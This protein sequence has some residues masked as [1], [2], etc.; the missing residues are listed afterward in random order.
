[1]PPLRP[2]Y[3]G[4][5]LILYIIGG[6]FVI[7]GEIRAQEDIITTISNI[8]AR[9]GA[10]GMTSGITA[11]ALVETW[12]TGMVLA[13]GIK[14]WMDK[15]HKKELEAAREEV[16]KQWRD[17]NARRLDAESRGEPFAEPPPNGKVN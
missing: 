9:L 17:W 12:R 16:N 2:W 13:H 8:F 4:I 5:F 3:F 14:Q 11:F 1:M 6:G 7:A 15:R 10:A